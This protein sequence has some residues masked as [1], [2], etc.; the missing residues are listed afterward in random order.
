MPAEG[1]GA[2][3]EKAQQVTLDEMEDWFRTRRR[4]ESGWSFCRFRREPRTRCERWR[5]RFVDAVTGSE[6]RAAA[7]QVL[8]K[9]FGAGTIMSTH[10]RRIQRNSRL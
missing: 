2:A 10:G 5:F 4:M 1:A 7:I 6:Y 8:G 3:D 9:V